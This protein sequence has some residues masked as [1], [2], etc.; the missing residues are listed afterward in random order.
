M[1]TVLIRYR[2]DISV[3]LNR[4]QYI[5]ELISI[6]CL[7]NIGMLLH[8]YQYIIALISVCYR[9]NI[10]SISIHYQTCRIDIDTLSNR[11]VK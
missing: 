2:I 11:E 8:R 10:K 4:Y 6:C 9:I 1:G 3:L 5:T 7:I